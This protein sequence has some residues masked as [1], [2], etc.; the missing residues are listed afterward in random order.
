MFYATTIPPNEAIITFIKIWNTIKIL[1][2]HSTQS[3]IRIILQIYMRF[4]MEI[5]R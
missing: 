3:L 2:I 5:Q 1:E 4:E